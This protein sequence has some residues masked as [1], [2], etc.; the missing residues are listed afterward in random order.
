MDFEYAANRLKKDHAEL[1]KK[2]KKNLTLASNKATL[3][4]RKRQE[5]R[6]RQLEK[7]KEKERVEKLK[8]DHVRRRF[9][10]LEHKLGVMRNLM[11]TA[12]SSPSPSLSQEAQ[13]NIGSSSPSF[14]LLLDATSVHGQG[15]KIT[16]PPSLLSTLADKDLLRSSQERGQPLFFRLGIRR[17]NYVFPESERMKKFMNEYAVNSSNTSSSTTRNSTFME[18]V[19]DAKRSSLG[20]DLVSSDSYFY[21]Y[22]VYRVVY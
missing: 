3:E 18:E 11:S 16:L 21:S 2:G 14:S 19:Q 6:Q 7:K 1:R 9:D 20:T 15:D 22:H 8:L 4:A 10:I 13:N 17:P 12:S 5:Y